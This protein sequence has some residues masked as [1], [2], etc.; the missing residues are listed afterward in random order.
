MRGSAVDLNVRLEAVVKQEG[1]AWLASC[2]SLDVVTQDE[3]KQA[4]L[5]ALKEA[6][7]LWFESSIERGVL[8]QALIEA[9]F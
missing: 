2:P 6:V 7:Q 5:E 4:A 9:G 1:G 3:S 8:D